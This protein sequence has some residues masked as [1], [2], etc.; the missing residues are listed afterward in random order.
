M[1]SYPGVISNPGI[2]GEKSLNLKQI[3]PS[4]VLGIEMT[5]AGICHRQMTAHIIYVLT[6]KNLTFITTPFRLLNK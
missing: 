1:K 3:S 6:N 5:V 2:P 4:R